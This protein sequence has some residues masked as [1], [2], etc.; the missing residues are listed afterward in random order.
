MTS[1]LQHELLRTIEELAAFGEKRAGTDAGARA[2]EYLLDRFRRLGLDD[3]HAQPFAFPRHDLA[4]ASLELTVDGEARPAAFAALE[5]SGTGRV[6]AEVVHVGWATP[7]EL[8]RLTLAGKVALVDRNPLYHRSTQYYDVAF[9]GAAALLFASTAPSN[10]PQVGSVRREWEAIGPIPA[11]TIGSADARA[12]RDAL[13]AQKPVRAR[14][15]VD[16]TVVRAV[17]RNVVGRVHGSG[18]GEL[19]VGAHFDTWFSGSTDNGGGVAAMLA[20]AERRAHQPPA[21]YAIR[22]VAWD[23]EELALYGGYH[24]LRRYALDATRPL[25][26]IDFETPS[27]IGAQAYGLARSNHAPLEEAIVGVGLHELF[28]LNVPLDLVAELFGGVIPTDIQGLYRAGTPAIATAVD[29]PYYHTVEDTPDKVDLARLEETVLAFDRALDRL[30]SAAPD[31]FGARDPALWRAEVALQRRDGDLIVGVRVTDAAGRAQ[32]GALV[33][34]VLFE[35]DFF[36]RATLHARS[37]PDGTVALRFAG[38][39]RS[40]VRRFL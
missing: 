17:G 36:A 7:V 1:A 8:A 40:E 10:L 16:A 6:D 15:A 26:V 11:L 3:V 22:F 14:L 4:S 23:G 31:R 38:A 35:D 32:A 19:V 34:A 27:A 5:A 24:L 2:A 13:A 30:M 28:A 12:L 29:A 9:A 25:A 20:L 21:R 18:E 37:A 39:A 33:E